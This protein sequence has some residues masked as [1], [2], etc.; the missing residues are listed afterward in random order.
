MA[1]NFTNFIIQLLKPLIPKKIMIFFLKLKLRVKGWKERKGNFSQFE[2][3]FS[4][5]SLC[6]LIVHYFD[7]WPLCFQL[8]FTFFN[9]LFEQKKNKILQLKN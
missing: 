6:T 4:K 8:P 7:C 1:P 3:I 9:T 2:S 5:I